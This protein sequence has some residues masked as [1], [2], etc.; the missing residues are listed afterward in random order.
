MMKCPYIGFFAYASSCPSCLT[1]VPQHHLPD[2]PPIPKSLSQVLLW[3]VGEQGTQ[4]KTRTL[5][6]NSEITKFQAG[7]KA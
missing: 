7:I 5:K 3:G 4:T 2:E 6:S 1:L